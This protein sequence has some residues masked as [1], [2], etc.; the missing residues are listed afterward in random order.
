MKS[1]LFL[2][3]VFF[4]VFITAQ[5]S[6]HVYELSDKEVIS[7]PVK[8]ILS[9]NIKDKQFVFLGESFHKSGADLVKKTD[10][11][12]YLV[13]EEGFKNIIFESGFYALYNEHSKENLYG[14]WSQSEQCQELFTFL[15]KARVTMWGMDNKFHTQFSK[16]NFPIEFQKKLENEKISFTSKYMS[17]VDKVLKLEFELKDQLGKDDLEYFDMETQRI[18]N[19]LK[20][21]NQRFWYQAIQNLKSCSLTYREKDIP[22]SIAERDT[23]MAK[24]LNFLGNYYPNKK[25]IVWAANAHI[26]KTTNDYMGKTTMGVEF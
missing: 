9:K 25:F 24:N 14:V 23:Q 5:I 26:A 15:D 2:I 3:V 10:F 4:P 12:K 17:I 16:S 22:L 21:S 11:V 7:Q 6:E 13:N 18:L 20:H 8:D 1:F 19:A